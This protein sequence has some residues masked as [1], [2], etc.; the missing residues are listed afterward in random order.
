[1]SLR[2]LRVLPALDFGGVETRVCLHA[3]LHDRSAIDL[4]VL[5]FHEDGRAGRRIR[6][7]G[8]PVHVLGEHPAVRNFAATRALRRAL[9][10]LAPDIVH[11]SAPEA[12]FHA[13]IAGNAAGVPRI[14]L[15]EVG[16]A[17][18]R[19]AGRAVFT[20][21]Y[22]TVDAVVVV[23]EA[24]REHLERSERLDRAR[25]IYTCAQ[26]RFLT[27]LSRDYARPPPF[28]FLVTGRLV[29]QKNVALLIDAFAA[30]DRDAELW[31]AGDGPLRAELTRRM[32]ERGL[33]DR[34][35]ILGFRGDVAE[36]LDQCDAYLFAS[37]WGEGVSNALVEALARGAP[38]AASSV[39]GN[40]EVVRELGPAWSIDPDDRAA[41]TSAMRRLIDMTPD[42]RRAHGEAGR[43]I[44]ETRFSPERHL[45]AL[46]ALYRDVMKAPRTMARVRSL[47][48]S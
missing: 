30:L 22:R 8:V 18:R 24:L 11:A 10:E 21:L 38:C 28:R 6:E 19:R 20:A 15:E 48:R 45:A 17:S 36:L 31:I 39:P 27:P 1:M 40:P 46:D 47:I 44:A 4:S 13:A 41:W 5:T 29:P 12:M 35:K 23:S 42:E 14:V 9:R 34:A 7:A 33:N 25:L 43:K 2:V 26:P 32:A 16:I 37:A 3:E